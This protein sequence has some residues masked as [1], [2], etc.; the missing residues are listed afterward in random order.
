MKAI[1]LAA[2]QGKRL[3]PLTNHKPKCMVPLFGK[4]LL[5]HQLDVMHQLSLPKENIALV[6]GY[7]MEELASS[8]L[9]CFFNPH[10]ATS[11]MV[12]SLFCAAEFMS[13]D[14]DLIISY[15]DIIYKPKV[16][17]ALLE[18]EGEIVVAA[19]LEWER[20][21]S[22]RMDNP[23]DDA[24]TFMVDDLGYVTELGKR[25]KSNAECHAQ[26]IGLIKIKAGKINALKRYYNNLDPTS[27]YDGNDFRNMYMTT[28]IQQLIYSG[29]KVRPAFIR[30]GWLEVDTV[31][32]L[33][34]YERLKMSC[35]DFF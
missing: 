14:H 6:S 5:H 25:P 20:L 15:G 31:T 29:W 2:G 23:L 28:F 21:W 17:E 7:L 1:V 18:T 32:D 11:N 12:L 19:D 16:L 10:Y 33:E 27:I 3:K 4:P 24:E 22:I 26:Y 8:G 13:E 30:G 35:G 34:L 9:R